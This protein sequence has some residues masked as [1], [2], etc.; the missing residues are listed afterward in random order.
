MHDTIKCLLFSST[1]RLDDDYLS[2]LTKSLHLSSSRGA[3]PQ[4]F[5]IILVSMRI[6]ILPS[7][8]SSISPV[9][10]ELSSPFLSICGGRSWKEHLHFLTRLYVFHFHFLLS[11][12]ASHIHMINES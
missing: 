12:L 4:H 7:R 2:P 8:A 5:L 3:F 9:P 6:M 10:E 1:I 11:H